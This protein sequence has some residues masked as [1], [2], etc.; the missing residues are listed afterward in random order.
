ME[1]TDSHTR[2][3]CLFVWRIGL[4]VYPGLYGVE[5]VKCTFCYCLSFTSSVVLIRRALTGLQKRLGCNLGEN[6]IW[7][8]GV[9]SLKQ[10][11]LLT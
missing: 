8:D 11:I 5:E 7:H 9:V 2:V 1:I 6:L 3:S 4:R 10:E